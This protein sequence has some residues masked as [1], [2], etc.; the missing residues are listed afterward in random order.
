MSGENSPN[1]LG[2]LLDKLEEAGRPKEEVSLEDMLQATG[3]RSF[4]ALLLVPG[5][6]VL[7]PLSG[8]PG[9]PTV[10]AI[11]VSLIALQLLMGRSHFW[12]PGWLLH[13]RA[14]RGKYRRSIGIL[15]KPARYIDRML[16]HRLTFLTQGV[17][18][19]INALLCLV[20]AA[21]MP[22]LELLPFGNS[23]AGA[24]LSIL[25]VG[26][27]A[28]DGAMILVALAFIG[29]LAYMLMQLWT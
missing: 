11:M 21:I 3:H 22:P 16:R 26:M 23:V 6:L 9:L 15:K 8:I 10:C 14:P 2:A 24:A 27:M 19:Y 13:R 12:L 7:S 20:I 28:R 25:G 5:L 29:A 1:T 4:G 18:V 17:A